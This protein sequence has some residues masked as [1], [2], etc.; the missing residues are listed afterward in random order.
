MDLTVEAFGK[1]GEVIH[2]IDRAPDWNK[3]KT[4]EKG[5]AEFGINVARKVRKLIIKVSAHTF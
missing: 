4:D 3:A 5:V 2:L 1:I